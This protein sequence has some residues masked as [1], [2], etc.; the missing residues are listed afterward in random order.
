MKVL[1]FGG[2]SVGNAERMKSVACVF[3]VKANDVIQSHFKY[4]LSFTEDMF[5]LFEEKAILAQGELLS[6]TL[7]Y[8][9]LKEQKIDAVLLPALNF[10]RI[11]KDSEPDI[12]YIKENLNRELKKHPNTK[13]F[14][15]QG[16]I[17]RNTFGE[18]DNLKRGGSDYSAS[19]IGATIKAEEIEIWTDIDGMHNNDPRFVENTKPLASL[20]WCQNFTSGK[21]H[22]S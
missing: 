13:I 11:D 14:I 6:T 12:F 21:C 4:I 5:T 15:T 22:A 8:L 17:C 2:T 3:K 16:F 7:F 18:V 10:M 9:Y 20:F 1:K 19:L